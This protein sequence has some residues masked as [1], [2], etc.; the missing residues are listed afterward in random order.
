MPV[1]H[2]GIYYGA[3]LHKEFSGAF[4][5]FTKQPD[6]SAIYACVLGPDTSTYSR[7]PW[8]SSYT[9]MTSSSMWCVDLSNAS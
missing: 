8:Y 1:L 7:K 2:T 5:P 4:E 9:S 3:A 6:E